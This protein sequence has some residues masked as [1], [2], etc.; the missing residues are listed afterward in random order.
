MP[1]RAR[2]ASARLPG[3]AAGPPGGRGGTSSAASAGPGAHPEKREG[4]LLHARDAWRARCAAAGRTSPLP[5][6]SAASRA[7]A[8]TPIITITP[9]QTVSHTQRSRPRVSLPQRRPPGAAVPAQDITLVAQAPLPAAPV[10]QSAASLQEQLA[11]LEASQPAPAP[12]PAPTK[13]KHKKGAAA[14]AGPAPSP[15][16]ARLL[17]AAARAREHWPPPKGGAR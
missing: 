3:R 11:A 10:P 13:K 5:A 1:I 2:A 12:A 9:S 17:S 14:A 4:S 15:K 8:R 7:A 6:A 16:K